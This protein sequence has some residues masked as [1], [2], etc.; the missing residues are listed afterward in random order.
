MAAPLSS[1]D[2]LIAQTTKGG[3]SHAIKLLGCFQRSEAYSSYLLSG[4]RTAGGRIRK[5]AKSFPPGTREVKP[6]TTGV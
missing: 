3:N 1:S 5:G 4:V 6:K 2:Q